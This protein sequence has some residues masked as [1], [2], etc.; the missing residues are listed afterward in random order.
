MPSYTR[1]D[2]SCQHHVKG[3][4]IVMIVTANGDEHKTSLMP[5]D[6]VPPYHSAI[7]FKL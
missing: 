7:Y 1:T 4:Q 6:L 5:N 2:I 3:S